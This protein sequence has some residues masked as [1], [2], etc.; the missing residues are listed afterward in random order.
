MVVLI[1]LLTLLTA[2][3]QDSTLKKETP[4]K[5]KTNENIRV[6]SWSQPI[7]EQTNLLVDEEKH[8]KS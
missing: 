3:N 2:C 7:T 1:G 5:E 4:R 6:A 8:F